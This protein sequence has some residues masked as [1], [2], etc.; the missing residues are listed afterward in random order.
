[1]IQWRQEGAR[2]ARK[3]PKE[4]N[5]MNKSPVIPRPEYPNPQFA[6]ADWINLNGE[7]EFEAD[8]SVSGRARGN[9]HAAAFPQR[10][11]V[12]FCMES[13]LSGIGDKD[14]CN[15]VWYRR[16]VTLPEGFAGEGKRVF[17]HIGACD[18]RTEVYINGKSA[19]I[20]IGG[21]ISFCFDITEYLVSG[22]NVIIICA[23]DDVRRQE[24]AAGKQCERYASYGCMYTRTTGIW[25]TVWLESTPTHYMKN[26]RTYTD[27]ENATVTLQVSTT[28]GSEAPVKAKAFYHGIPVGEAEGR[29]TDG[30]CTLQFSLSEL[31][32]W[33]AGKGELYD[34][35]LS[36]GEDRVK[37]YFGMRSVSTRNGI[38]YLNGKPH[39]Q[40]LILDQGFYPDG[41]YTAPSEEALIADITRSMDMGFEG[42]RLH[43]KIFEPLFLYHADRLGYMVWGEH[44]NWGLDLSRPAAWK[45]FVSEWQEAL[46]RDCNHPAIIGWCPLNETQPNQDDDFV[47][48]IVG[49]TRAFD[50]TRP[51][52]DTSGWKHIKGLSDIEDYHDYNQD[53]VSFN[54]RYLRVAAGEALTETHDAQWLTPYPLRPTFISEY[55]GIR[56][57]L[58]EAADGSWGYGQA[59]KT[60]EEFLERL[61]G[62]TEALLF[63]PG[64]GGLCYTQLTDVEQEINGL[65]TYDRRPK[66]DPAYLK[67]ILS[68][69]AA[70]EKDN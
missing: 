15:C 1:M 41:I 25:Q 36:F 13:A 57:S 61:K 29:A 52:L 67:A 27:I 16:S 55:G 23:E 70:I 40:R 3:D 32:L 56:W 68:Q 60:H 39:F 53:P 31:H 14:F 4:E 44:A 58:E 5:I 24:Q 18:W 6:R 37:S 20:H 62:L 59:P 28:A 50:K 9:M 54:E 35:E 48:Y 33:D 69:T 34:L 19:G 38:L 26:F 22:E 42:A 45:G 2:L 8:R 17:L 46:E 43:E 21:Y 63:N 65:Y 12:P 49:M 66:L 30:F 47:R 11:T 51:V 10:I 64:M 7:W